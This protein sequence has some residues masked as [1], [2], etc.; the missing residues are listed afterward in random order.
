MLWKSITEP[1]TMIITGFAECYN[2]TYG[3]T[4]DF[5]QYKIHIE[6]CEQIQ[7]ESCGYLNLLSIDDFCKLTPLEDFE[8]FYCNEC[9]SDMYILPNF[10]GDIY[11]KK[12]NLETDKY[13]E[14]DG[15]YDDDIYI[16]VVAL[17]KNTE[18]TTDF[19]SFPQIM[20]KFKINLLFL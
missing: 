20:D 9:D 2:D 3:I 16:V 4:D 17:P 6:E 7:A 5:T 14:Y 19:R 12:L 10:V 1:T 13:F 11:I 15:E 18:M 8:N